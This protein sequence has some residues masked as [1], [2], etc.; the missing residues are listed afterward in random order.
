[1]THKEF[2]FNWIV[3]S[4]LLWFTMVVTLWSVRFIYLMSI[5]AI[6][7][8]GWPI[9]L[10]GVFGIISIVI[11][12]ACTVGAHLQQRRAIINVRRTMGLDKDGHE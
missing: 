12:L 2:A 6:A 10:S 9:Y 8:Y 3:A 4:V 11:G 7:A 1:M 5:V